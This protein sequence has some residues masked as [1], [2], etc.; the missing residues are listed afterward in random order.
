MNL[1]TLRLRTVL[2]AAAVIGLSMMGCGGDNG[3][4]PQPRT[5]SAPTGLT[6]TA[7]SSTDITLSWNAVGGAAGYYVYVS[8]SA[9]SG[10]VL[11]ETTVTNGL[12]AIGA[13]PGTTYYFRVSAVSADGTE[14]A[15]SNV[16]SATT[17]SGVGGGIAAPAGLTATAVSS[18]E[19]N[20][21]WNAVIGAAGYKV[22]ASG[23]ASSGF[24][25]LETS[26]T[27]SFRAGGAE[28]DVTYY[29]K[30]SAVS[31]NGTES[32]MSNVASATT[33]TSGGNNTYSL[34]GIWVHTGGGYTVTVNGNSSILSS[35]TDTYALW[36]DAINKGYIQVGTSQYWRNLTSTGNLTWSGQALSVGFYT[37]NPNVAVDANWSNVTITMSANGQT[38]TETYT[39]GKTNTFT[40]GNYSLNGVWANNTD[41]ITVNGNSGI[42]SSYT[43]TYALWLSAINKGYIKVGTSQ[44]WRNLTSAG[45]LTWSGQAL[46][47]THKTSS[48][49]VAEGTSYVNVTIT[50]NANGQTITVTYTDGKTLI[51]TRQR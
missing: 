23:S 26:A 17:Y 37:S 36:L 34:D 31:A 30:V 38:I 21:S 45:N 8:L 49:N 24:V 6:A 7:T 12:R 10:F 41:V 46:A 25:L 18:T 50:I 40:R 29:F 11:Y 33:R 20:L 44:Y 9:S 32:A 3:T 47:V 39:D 16:A 43:D 19:I 27:N 28:P 5:L 2:L 14:S 13:D 42:L 15:M 4:D 1:F 22:Y 35:Y 48:P 51:Y